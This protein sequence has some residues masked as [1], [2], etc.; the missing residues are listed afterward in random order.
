MNLYSASG[1]SNLKSGTLIAGRSFPKEL[2]LVNP[3]QALVSGTI[4][5][6]D[7]PWSILQNLHKSKIV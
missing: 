7:S 1:N 5:E 4:T 3:I 2:L 6:G